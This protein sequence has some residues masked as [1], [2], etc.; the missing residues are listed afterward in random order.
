MNTPYTAYPP[1]DTPARRSALRRIRRYAVPRAMIERATERRLA[2]DWRGACAA[3]NV[4]VRLDP[5]AARREHGTEFADAL[6]DDLRHL[7]PDLVRWHHPRQAAD[8]T[9]IDAPR[10]PV[11]SRPGGDRGPWLT[12]R[13][14]HPRT[15]RYDG[16]GWSQRLVLE[17]TP[18]EELGLDA[19]FRDR[20]YEP[21]LWT[22][23]RYLWDSRHV[24]ETRERWG[25]GPDRAPFLNPDG[26]PRTSAALPTADPGHADPAAR[27]EWLDRLHGAE[28]TSQALAA[29]GIEAADAG[30]VHALARFPLSAGRWRT[31]LDGL[32][33]LGHGGLTWFTAEFSRTF[34]VEYGGH[35]IRVGLENHYTTPPGPTV[36]LPEV[37]WARPVDIG[38]VLAG[39][40]P[41]HLHPVVRDALA[42]ARPPAG[43]P[44]G[45]PPWEPLE[46]V[47]VRC[48]GEWHTLV[49]RD[50]RLVGPHT[51]EERAR[52]R[53]IRALGGSSSP[54]FRATETWRSGRGWLPKGLK[55]RRSE[56]FERIRHGDT[57]TVLA[58]LDGG[59]DPH[60][61][62]GERNTLLHELHHLDHT[63]LLPRL[64]AAGLDVDAE[65]E[66]GWT[67]V[68]RALR[69]GGSPA[70]ARALVAAG[71]RVHRTGTSD[72]RSVDLAPALEGLLRQGKLADPAGW[73]EL[74]REL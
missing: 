71:A 48:G 24:H 74:L 26:T 73:E 68:H 46:P 3:A 53:A 5:D 23:S 50:G 62:D 63:V 14:P 18:H 15:N 8:Q 67:P 43:G 69:F 66:A 34:A 1:S 47:R 49:L 60:V 19:P 65:N 64:L 9:W 28:G 58:Y 30:T 25:G 20:V 2:G 41:D 59:G 52:E 54:C 4:D 6:L 61:R 38:M 22:S 51:E 7:V 42:P 12:V 45:P 33:A 72:F 37:C 35:R 32:A 31:E 16:S 40:S 17:L 27:T 70:L 29:A 44:V 55:A 57:G 10:F 56:L 13:S 39:M 36:P 11:L 21:Q